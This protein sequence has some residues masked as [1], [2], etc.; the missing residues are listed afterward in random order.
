VT[1]PVIVFKYLVALLVVVKVIEKVITIV[2]LERHDRK[3]WVVF[4]CILTT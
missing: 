2:I 4:K 3:N 1:Q